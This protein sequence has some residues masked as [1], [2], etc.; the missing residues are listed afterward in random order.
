MELA[1]WELP[2]EGQGRKEFPAMLK[3][4]ENL[5]REHILSKIAIP[6][7]CLPLRLFRYD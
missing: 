1:V 7:V 5:W 4:C 6:E 2:R 3:A